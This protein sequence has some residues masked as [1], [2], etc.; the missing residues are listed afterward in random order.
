MTWR[1]RLGRDG[2]LHMGAHPSS[3]WFHQ[4]GRPHPSCVPL[5]LVWVSASWVSTGCSDHWCQAVAS[6]ILL[7]WG[8]GWSRLLGPVGYVPLPL[9]PLW[10]TSLL[11]TNPGS[12][13]CAME[14]SGPE[15]AECVPLSCT[16]GERW[17]G[18]CPRV[19]SPPCLAG[20][21]GCLGRCVGT[22]GDRREKPWEP[23]VFP[24]G[25]F[26]PSLQ[27]AQEHMCGPALSCKP[28]TTAWPTSRCMG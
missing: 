19:L 15:K 10:L 7:G 25:C 24:T 4:G 5:A 1:G 20:A 11:V 18:D 3:V 26:L 21:A 22:A 16:A 13:S 27:T 6:G 12:L 8:C 14:K 2:Y 28:L 17:C 9:A 23:A